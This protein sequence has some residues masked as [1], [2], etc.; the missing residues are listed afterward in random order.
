MQYE[1]EIEAKEIYK[2]VALSAF[3]NKSYKECSK[4]LSKL[5]NLTNLNK[6]EREKFHELAISIFTKIDPKNSK[7]NSFQCPG[8]N[9]ENL[10]SE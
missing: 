6:E 7:E 1:K 4:A 10:I 8:K 5:E 2:L 3:L 9:C